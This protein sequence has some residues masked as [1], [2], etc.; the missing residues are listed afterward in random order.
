MKLNKERIPRRIIQFCHDK[1]SL[2]NELRNAANN[3]RR[4]QWFYDYRF[5]DD[6]SVVAFIRQ[7]YCT[8]TLNLYQN[9]HIAA[10]RCD[11]ARLLILY[12]LGGFYVDLSMEIKSSL[13][14][15]RKNDL[16]LLQRDDMAVKANRDPADAHCTNSIIG[17]PPESAYIEKC[18][19]LMRQRLRSRKY[20]FDVIQATGPGILNTVL[21]EF[22]NI[23]VCKVPFSQARESLFNYVRIQKFSN[24]WTEQQKFGIYRD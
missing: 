20:N 12:K 24:T 3:T 23:Q 10:S 4:S 8:D 18:L 13:S 1:T 21:S 16:V 22:S 6:E 14:L 2:P 9:N 11:M 17:V 15:F 19:M 5:F 7:H